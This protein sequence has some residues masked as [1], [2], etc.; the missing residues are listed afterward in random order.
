MTIIMK[1]EPGDLQIVCENAF[2]QIIDFPIYFDA[3]KVWFFYFIMKQDFTL[4]LLRGG[5]TGESPHLALL[6]V[7]LIKYKLR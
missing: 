3:F 7:W 1:K 6:V 2:L 5:I 4:G